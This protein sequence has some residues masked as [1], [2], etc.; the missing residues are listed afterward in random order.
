GGGGEGGRVGWEGGNGKPVG[1][2]KL[3]PEY[4][5]QSP[6]WGY[7]AHPL[8][9]GQKLIT[10]AGGEGS[11]VVAL[12]KDTGRELWK[13]GTQKQIGYSPPVIIQ[14]GGTRQ[15]IVTRQ[16]AVRSLD[17]DTGKQHWAQPLFSGHD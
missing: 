12:D 3:K 1:S 11:H 7:A 13:S 10:L 6:L 2:K 15:L 16:T 9:D 4:K 17:P 14:A 5:T 8:I